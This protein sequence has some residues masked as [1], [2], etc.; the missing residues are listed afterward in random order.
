MLLIYPPVA[1]PGEPPAGIARLAGALGRHGIKHR[2]VDANLEGLLFLLQEPQAGGDTWTKR[3]WKNRDAHLAG[4]KDAALYRSRDRYR[5]AILDLE[6]VL[7][8]AS[9][10]HGARVGLADFQHP[11]LSPHKSGD[12]LLA[13]ETF[14]ENPFFPYF[15]NRLAPIIEN[16]GSGLVGISLNY[17]SQAI[18]AFALIG[19][20]KQR[21]PSVRI[22][23]GGG[24]AT[25]WIRGIGQSDL[26]GGL[27]DALIAGP[28][29][30]ELL[31]LAGIAAEDGE[32]CLPEYAA[33]PLPDYLSPGLIVPY[34]GSS[35]CWWNHCS[36]CPE[37]AEGNP[38]LPI[39]AG[40]LT[41]ELR[42][43][44]S[45]HSPSLIHLLDNAV[46][47]GHMRAMIEDPPDAPWYGFAR[48]GKELADEE[49]CRS[50]RR[51]GCVMLKLGLES[52]D[53]DVLDG[54]GKGM[55]LDVA[56]KTLRSLKKAGIAAF[57]YLLFGTPQEDRSAALR[58][59]AFTAAHSDAIAFLNLAIFNMPV[60]GE[61]AAQFGTRTFS[62]GDL[63]L[64]TDFRHPRGWDRKEV[65][66]FLSREFTA[67]PA[68]RPII[69]RELPVFG[70]NHAA[71]FV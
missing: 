18:S 56:G 5:R 20:I 42:A 52:G 67:H 34:S 35:G 49:F 15:E 63:S 10:R 57:V 68:I 26:F 58:T 4:L 2:V 37:R 38:Y 25:S 19:F 70:S 53:Q 7:E 54:L 65:R 22:V 32:P 24:L 48:A 62:E 59:L 11:T 8:T 71:F 45:K 66:K 1:K 12:L 17:L 28:G 47:V 14:A 16:E 13:A 51:S 6:R 21:F 61:E 64:Y 46:S 29:E 40:V 36:F 55:D 33:L 27:V 31:R 69:N 9:A 50:L 60:R 30:R 43:L 23:L 39:A 41:A 44:A 3:A